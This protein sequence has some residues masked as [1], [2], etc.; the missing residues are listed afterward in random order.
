MI[1]LTHLKNNRGIAALSTILLFGSI[2]V[3]IAIATA[4]MAFILNN[5]NYGARLSAEALSAAKAGVDDAT[6]KLSRNKDFAFPSSPGYELAVG[7]R[8]ATVL[9]CKDFKTAAGANPCGAIPNVG[10]YEVTST[11]KAVNKQ[12][13][14]RAIIDVDP[15]TGLTRVVSKEEVP[16]Q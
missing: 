16:F 2:I 4:F 5:I 10:K 6:L 15:Q 12:R 1:Y 7:N 8:I 9:V 14:L 11:G 3:E 13:K